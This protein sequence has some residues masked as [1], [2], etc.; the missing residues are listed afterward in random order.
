M[1]AFPKELTLPKEIEFRGLG[2]SYCAMCDGS[3]YEDKRVAIIGGGDTAAEDA[4]YLSR[5]CSKVYLIHRR[6]SLRASNSLQKKLFDNEK[7]DFIWDSRL[8]S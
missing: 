3:F 8:K 1:G 2:V 4:L 5:L 6:N 7:I